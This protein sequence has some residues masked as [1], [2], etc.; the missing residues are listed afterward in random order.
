MK[1]IKAMTATERGQKLREERIARGWKPV[2][3]WLKPEAVYVLDATVARNQLMGQEQTQ[4]D[5][6]NDALLRHYRREDPDDTV[7]RRKE[8]MEWTDMMEQA[9]R[10]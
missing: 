10:G 4:N 2:A 9:H 7:K 6:I 1:G 3:L 5:L 8:S